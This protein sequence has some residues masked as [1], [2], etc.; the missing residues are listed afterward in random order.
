M[1]S[2]MEALGFKS[3]E[4]VMEALASACSK[5]FVSASFDKELNLTREEKLALFFT[6]GR[7]PASGG[8]LLAMIL[9]TET[10]SEAYERVVE[11]EL[12]TTEDYQN[13]VGF[14]MTSLQGED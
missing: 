13:L 11:E 8:V 3:E 14:V 1:A 9:E 10:V 5:A 6:G 7:L 4:E 2:L 12:F